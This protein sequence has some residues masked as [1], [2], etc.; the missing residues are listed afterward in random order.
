MSG[1]LAILV[2]TMPMPEDVL[3]DL[4]YRYGIRKS[5]NREQEQDEFD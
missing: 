1:R 4:E 2:I 3:T 5:I